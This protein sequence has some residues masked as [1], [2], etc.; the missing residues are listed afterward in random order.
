M[1]FFKIDS[2]IIFYLKKKIIDVK[3][4]GGLIIVTLIA[5]SALAIVMI[6]VNNFTK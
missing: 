4:I 5:V 2:P 1:Q 3:I 6:I